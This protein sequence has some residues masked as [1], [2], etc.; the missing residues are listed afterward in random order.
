MQDEGKRAAKIT[1]ER[2]RATVENLSVRE[3]IQGDYRTLKTEYQTNTGIRG[4]NNEMAPF[5]SSLPPVNVQNETDDS[6]QVKAEE[7]MKVQQRLLQNP[8]LSLVSD[9]L[10]KHHLQHQLPPHLLQDPRSQQEKMSEINDKI[11]CHRY[12][13]QRELDLLLRFG[14][15]VCVSAGL[16]K[17]HLEDRRLKAILEG[18]A[19]AEILETVLR[20]WMEQNQQRSPY[21][22]ILSSGTVKE[23]SLALQEMHS[24][25]RCLKQ[26]METSLLAIE[27]EANFL[28]KNIHDTIQKLYGDSIYPIR[29]RNIEISKPQA[30]PHPHLQNRPSASDGHHAFQTK[31]NNEIEPKGQNDITINA[32]TIQPLPSYVD[33]LNRENIYPQN[34]RQMSQSMQRQYEQQ[35][36]QQQQSIQHQLDQRLIIEISVLEGKKWAKDK[37]DKAFVA[38]M[39][40]INAVKDEFY[41]NISS[42]YVLSTLPEMTG[43]HNQETLV[44]PQQNQQY[45]LD[46]NPPP[47]V[48]QIGNEKKRRKATTKSVPKEPPQETPIKKVTEKK[49]KKSHS[50]RANL[51]RQATG[52]LKL[53][54][55]DNFEHPYPSEKEK[56]ELM[57]TCDIN[58][59]QLNNWFIN[60]RVRYWKPLVEKLFNENKAQI[61]EAASR[62]KS[63]F[64]LRKYNE[65]LA[66]GQVRDG[67]RAPGGQ[68][69]SASMSA[70]AM[71]S[72]LMSEDSIANNVKIFSEQLRQKVKMEVGPSQEP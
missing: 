39:T 14:I 3:R 12:I 36:Q 51:S 25:V 63:G 42:S 22:P 11:V 33:S 62:D 34:E 52:I 44:F 23:L 9:F 59:P 68:V 72:C 7:F 50:A 67:E 10:L 55:H 30:F 35:Q 43:L 60:T 4:T 31:T 2:K 49:P 48:E 13:F 24:V 38:F 16:P 20:R 71:M 65:A 57:V 1:S 21:S 41:R 19:E 28:M 53:W 5:T 47:K 15:S 70:C 29:Q 64:L 26:R 66:R 40:V 18:P 58:L 69:P 8:F 56:E 46:P 54:L 27:Q 6:R 45:D 32:Q 61:V 37:L 17:K